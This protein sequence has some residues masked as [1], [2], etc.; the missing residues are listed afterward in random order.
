MKLKVIFTNFF[1]SKE[2][3]FLCITKKVR[4]SKRSSD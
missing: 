4:F 3:S 2:Q 1:H